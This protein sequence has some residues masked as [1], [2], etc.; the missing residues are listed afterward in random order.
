[1]TH[2]LAITLVP[3]RDDTAA[4]VDVGHD[5]ACHRLIKRRPAIGARKPA[6]PLSARL[7]VLD[8]PRTV[9]SSDLVDFRSAMIKMQAKHV[10]THAHP[11]R[12]S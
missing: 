8:A 6:P 11:P 5:G 3:Q 2:L 7:G 1:M 10:I 9:A 12:R 4:R